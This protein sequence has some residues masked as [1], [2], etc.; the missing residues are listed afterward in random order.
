[1]LFVIT[2]SLFPAAQGWRRTTWNT[3]SSSS[4]DQYPCNRNTWSGSCSEPFSP[5][6]EKKRITFIRK[7]KTLFSLQSCWTLSSEQKPER[8]GTRPSGPQQTLCTWI[9][10]AYWPVCGWSRAD[11]LLHSILMGGVVGANDHSVMQTGI[12]IQVNFGRGSWKW[13]FF[14]LFNTHL[15]NA[16]THKHKHCNIP[17]LCCV[18]R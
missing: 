11:W 8:T 17:S 10:I 3:N 7:K 13:Y 6:H 16:N 15:E 2:I 12:F 14:N 9:R 4:P 18:P 5:G 1:M